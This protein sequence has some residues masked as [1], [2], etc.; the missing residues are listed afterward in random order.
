[1]NLFSLINLIGLLCNSLAGQDLVPEPEDEVETQ[2]EGKGAG[3]CL[4]P[5]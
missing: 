1:M 5:V 2:Q 4:G 3:Q